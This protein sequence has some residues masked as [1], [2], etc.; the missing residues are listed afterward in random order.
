MITLAAVQLLYDY[1]YWR[2]AR[3]LQSCELLTPSQWDQ[4]M[5]PSWGSVHGLLAHMIAAENIWLGRWRGISAK[6]MMTADE[7]PAFEDVHAAWIKMEREMRSFIEECDDERL[8]SNITYTNTSG[9]TYTLP[10]GALMCHVVDHATH[11]R[12]ELVAMLTMLD[13][14]HP[15][16][17]LVGY[18]IMQSS[19]Q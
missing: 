16:D 1:H 18:L 10:L 14:P 17:G 12:G 5:A 19:K 15:D 4:P 9:K 8:S 2:T 13:V 6:A 7:L 3:I 11:H